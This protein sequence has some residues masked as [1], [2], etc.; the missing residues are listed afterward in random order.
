MVED[1][2][3]KEV[4]VAVVVEPAVGPG[5]A[6]CVAARRETTTTAR[7]ATNAVCSRIMACG[8]Q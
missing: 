7:T 6:Y 1:V 2:V 8:C 4:V 3:V 5:E